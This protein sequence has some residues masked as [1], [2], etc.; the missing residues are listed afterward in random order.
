MNSAIRQYQAARHIL[1]VTY[2]AVKE[3]KLLVAVLSSI[4]GSLIDA[5]EAK[6]QEVPKSLKELLPHISHEHHSVVCQ[7]EQLVKAHKESPVT[8]PRSDKFVIC[9]NKFDMQYIT[10][11]DLHKFLEINAQILSK[12]NTVNSSHLN[13]KE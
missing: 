3:P 6:I 8:F 12:L 9:S 2:P 5:T 13:R 11:P 1:T 7:I 10:I 4:Y